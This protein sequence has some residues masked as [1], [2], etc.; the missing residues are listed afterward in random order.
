[1]WRRL[2]TKISCTYGTKEFSRLLRLWRPRFIPVLC[3][4]SLVFGSRG[5]PEA[6]LFVLLP[7][8]F[9]FVDRFRP[10]ALGHDT[11]VCGWLADG[12]RVKITL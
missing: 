10:A 6:L 5:D 2:A 11:R 4:G 1:M 3:L 8:T 12:H 9:V 7:G